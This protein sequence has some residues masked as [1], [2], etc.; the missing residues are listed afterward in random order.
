MSS[1]PVTP[2]LPEDGLRARL[3]RAFTARL[4]EA[5]A[6][7]D[8]PAGLAD[9][10]LAELEADDAAPGLYGV[11]SALT[12][13]AQEVRLQGRAFKA[14]DER[15]APVVEQ[16][17]AL[18][19]SHREALATARALAEDTAAERRRRESEN[20]RAAERR[21]RLEAF[22]LLFD[23]R[24]R[25]AR[26]VESSRALLRQAPRG[27]LQRLLARRAAR[28]EE[29][30]AA[31]GEGC[32]LGL[33]HLDDAL[34]AQGIAAIDCLGEPFDPHS[35]SVVDLEQ[36]DAADDGCVLAVYRRG[37]LWHGEV[38]RAAQVKVARRAAV[39]GDQ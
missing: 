13:L 39:G 8:P 9:E 29:A 32:R 26:G 20:A 36:T 21:V 37:Y 4:D 16:Q 30:V 2:Q 1:D 19:D 18:L 33:E 3:L 22:E 28:L 15:L 31:L 35:M 34:Q 10:I 5:L 7:E 12:A 27:L 24:E 6:A 14:L 17:R 25:L 23:L 38:L 11:W